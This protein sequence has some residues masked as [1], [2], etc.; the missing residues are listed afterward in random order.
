MDEKTAKQVI[1]QLKLLNFWVTSF[2]V[3]MLTC[4]VILGFLIFKVVS[5]LNDARESFTNFQTKTSE[6]LNVK[7]DLCR[8]GS[9]LSGTSY[10]KSE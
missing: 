2:G 8:S 6:T 9:P 10:C 4:L 1:R 5:A 3:I 7:D